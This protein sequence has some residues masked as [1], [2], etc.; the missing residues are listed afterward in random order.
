MDIFSFVKLF[1][2]LGLFI[3]GMMVMGNALEKIAGE[4]LERTLE[5]MTG[6]IFKAVGLGAVVTAII[7][8]SSATTVMIVGFVNAGIMSLKQAV[9]V[10]MG[11]NIGTTMTA[12]LLRL[13]G[14]SGTASIAMQLVTPSNFSYIMVA[15]GVI[16]V[17]AAKKKKKQGHRRDPS[18]S[19]RPLHRHE[20]HGELGFRAP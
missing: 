8:S 18:R 9:G 19:R 3:Y 15:V 2:G 12:Q 13:G 7:Q 14:D 16:L 5:S 20:C 11:A 17:M 6:N 1:G 4:K 10:I